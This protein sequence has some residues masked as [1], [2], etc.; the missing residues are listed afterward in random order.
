M[1]LVP[2]ITPEEER[3]LLAWRQV[4]QARENFSITVFGQGHQKRRV[5]D[6]EV[7]YR[8][9]LTTTEPLS[10]AVDD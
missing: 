8:V 3:V 9:R 1:A 5:Q 6:L 4:R 2:P 7:K 10:V